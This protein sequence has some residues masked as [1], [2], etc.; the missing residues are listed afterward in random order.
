[1]R[2]LVCPRHRLAAPTLRESQMPNS[3]VCVCALLYHF[4]VGC[5]VHSATVCSRL[6]GNT[7]PHQ[8]CSRNAT[9]KPTNNLN[10]TNLF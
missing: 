7:V 10:R 5:V 9:D 4:P 6:H 2:L 3:R 1:M 8:Q